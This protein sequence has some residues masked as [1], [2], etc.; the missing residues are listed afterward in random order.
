MQH[1]GLLSGEGVFRGY[2]PDVGDIIPE[3]PGIDT[4]D[5]GGGNPDT[6][7]F[8]VPDNLKAS[9]PQYGTVDFG[10]KVKL[11]QVISLINLI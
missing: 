9:V 1:L 10:I 5:I 3:P 7:C 2:S 8:L 11:L 6:F 4:L